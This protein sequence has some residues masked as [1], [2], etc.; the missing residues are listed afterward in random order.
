[1][2]LKTKL[3]YNHV[4]EDD[5]FYYILHYMCLSSYSKYTNI[6][7]KNLKHITALGHKLL[8]SS[9]S[10]YTNKKTLKHMVALGS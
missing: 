10:K 7:E 6:G 2:P 3:E 5:F 1:M 4:K 9:Y 8:C